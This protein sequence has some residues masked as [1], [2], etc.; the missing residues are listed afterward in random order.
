M[1]LTS[2]H[3]RV[4]LAFCSGKSYNRTNVSIRPVTRWARGK[5]NAKV[6]DEIWGLGSGRRRRRGGGQR[7]RVG[8]PSGVE[9]LA[10]QVGAAVAEGAYALPALGDVERAPCARVRHGHVPQAGPAAAQL[11]L[12]P[13]L[14][15][16]GRRRRAFS[17]HPPVCSTPSYVTR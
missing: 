17:T 14:G 5:V 10:A 6:T 15:L 3:Q 13:V 11:E 7:R 12:L 8:G 16:W 1:E 4:H 2:M 9:R